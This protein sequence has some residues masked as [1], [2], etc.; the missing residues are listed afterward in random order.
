MPGCLTAPV[1]ATQDPARRGWGVVLPLKLLAQ[2]KTR[3]GAYGEVG[4]AELALAFASDV[5]EAVLACPVVHRVLVVTDDPHA[6]EV[7][8]RPGAQ[9]VPDRPAGGLNGA[10]EHG[11]VLLRRWNP[12]LGIAALAADLPAL[13]PDD[14]AAALAAVRVR[15]F[16]PDTAGLGTTMLAAA[17]APLAPAFGPGSGAR[18]RASGADELRAPDALR[19]DVDT[20]AD[21][22][23]ALRLGV[24]PCTACVAGRLLLRR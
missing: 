9:V 3:L 6:A 23:E 4:R 21:L 13:R 12:A 16:V 18:H 10:L 20:P 22:Q 19:R 7:L 11:E 15:G 24:G 2:A 1:T 5:V 8:A 14:L 17:G